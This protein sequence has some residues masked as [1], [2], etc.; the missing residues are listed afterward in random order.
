MVW[1]SKTVATRTPVRGEH[2]EWRAK[3]TLRADVPFLAA[4]I[5][6]TADRLL[7]GRIPASGAHVEL[8][9]D[10]AFLPWSWHTSS[11]V[12]VFLGQR[13]PRAGGG[14]AVQIDS[15]PLKLAPPEHTT[16]LTPMTGVTATGMYLPLA[17]IAEE[18]V[19]SVVLVARTDVKVSHDRW[20][21]PEDV[22][23]PDKLGWLRTGRRSGEISLSED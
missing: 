1:E 11:E 10:L 16:F 9:L 3:A 19:A 2:T 14:Q 5:I 8:E 6:E 23:L 17:A 13:S 21:L 22:A 20:R 15:E 18:A 7:H 4:V 12:R